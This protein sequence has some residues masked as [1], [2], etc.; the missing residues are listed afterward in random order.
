MIDLPKYY[1]QM[2]K[3]FNMG[4]KV[5]G[6]VELLPGLQSGSVLFMTTA[7]L[8]NMIIEENWE[9]LFKYKYIAI[10]E[11]HEMNDPMI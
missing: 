1:P 3:G 6:K 9:E 11:V 2:I 7:I 4:Y 5:G 8:T 10:D